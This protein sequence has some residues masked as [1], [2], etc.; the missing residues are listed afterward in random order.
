MIELRRGDTAQAAR[1]FEEGARISGQLGDMLGVAYYVW[2]FGNVNARSGRPVR[3]A[4]LW[5]A[6]E[7]LRE[8]MGMSFSRYDLAQSGYEQDLAAVRSALDETSFDA[9]WAEG[10]AMSPEQAIEYALEEPMTPDQEHPADMASPA[11]LPEERQKEDARGDL[12][13][14]LPV[15]R[16][17]FVGREREISEVGRTLSMTRLLTLTGAGGCGKTRLALEVARDIVG[18]RSR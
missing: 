14:N 9:A 6:A 16:S 11:R 13:N 10:R 2:I 7:A 4:R 5:G 17:G 12:R 3:A 15:A 18:A 1:V 8:Q